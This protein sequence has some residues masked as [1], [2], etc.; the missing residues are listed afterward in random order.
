M[1]FSKLSLQEEFR[2]CFDIINVE[3]CLFGF[4]LLLYSYAPTGFPTPV[5]AKV[6]DKEICSH[7]A[8]IICE[9]PKYI[10]LQ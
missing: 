4:E 10:Q 7:L 9:E 6:V 5:C 1:A 8:R 3:T 2:T